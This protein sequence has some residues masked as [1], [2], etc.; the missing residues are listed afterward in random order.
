MIFYYDKEENKIKYDIDLSHLFAKETE[1]LNLKL[2]LINDDIEQEE[3]DE[4]CIDAEKIIVKCY[5]NNS[6]D[7]EDLGDILNLIDRKISQLFT[8]KK[9]QLNF[10]NLEC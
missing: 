2:E 8:S 9:I 7:I 6:A 3:F 1:E 5:E 10:Q 4:F